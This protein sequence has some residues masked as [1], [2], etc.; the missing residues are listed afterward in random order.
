MAA[1]R[2]R[3]SH[4]HHQ[5]GGKSF[6]HHTGRHAAQKHADDRCQRYR[7][8]PTLIVVVQLKVT[9]SASAPTE[10]HARLISVRP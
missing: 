6:E 4:S 1:R 7:Q 3:S 2:K 8:K 9:A 5:V 10:I